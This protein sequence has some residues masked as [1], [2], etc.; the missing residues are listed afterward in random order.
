MTTFI[1]ETLGIT[2]V[3][4]GKLFNY[5]WNECP[6]NILSV[7]TN[8]LNSKKRLGLSDLI[9]WQNYLKTL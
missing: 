4:N 8:K 6:Q 9:E 3:K 2:E 5:T 1:F 7:T